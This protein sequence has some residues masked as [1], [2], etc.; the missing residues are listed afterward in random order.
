MYPCY[1][2]VEVIAFQ[3]EVESELKNYI[4]EIEIKTDTGDRACR[5]FRIEQ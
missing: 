4:R 2:E 3:A 5:N 1:Q